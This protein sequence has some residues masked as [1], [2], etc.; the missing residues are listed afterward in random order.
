MNCDRAKMYWRAKQLQWCWA[1]WKRDFQALID[2][3]DPQVK[4]LGHDLM[5]Q[6]RLMFDTWWRS[7]Q[8][9]LSW[10]EFQRDMIPIRCKV[11]N[12][13]LRGV[14]SGNRR[15]VGMCRELWEHREWLWTFVEVQGVEPT[16]NTAERALRPAVIYR[17]LSFGTQSA[18]GSRFLERLLTVSE[19]CRL[20]GRSIFASL[21]AAQEAH[22]HNQP[23][24][25][26][27]PAE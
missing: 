9:K 14:F 25:S 13:L 18:S 1:H 27:L 5:R 24:P 26:L 22:F 16:N 17:K 11:D 20:Q 19:T 12:L 6:V 2:H 15:L 8:K 10:E 7:K 4:R 3:H 21:S 23:A